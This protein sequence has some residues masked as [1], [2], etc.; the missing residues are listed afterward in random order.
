MSFDGT[1]RS[2]PMKG[3]LACLFAATLCL[4]CQAPPGAIDPFIGRQTVPPPG[5]GT[6]SAAPPTDGYYSPASKTSV[7][8]TSP[9]GTPYS[10]PGNSFGLSNNSTAARPKPGEA[11]ATISNG[12]TAPNVTPATRDATRPSSGGTPV[13]PAGPGESPPGSS[14]SRATSGA[15]FVNS[16]PPRGLP[17]Q[18]ASTRTA[19]GTGARQTAPAASIRDIKDLPDATPAT[20]TPPSRSSGG[21][22]PVGSATR[23]N[24]EEEVQETRE[25]PKS[26]SRTPRRETISPGKYEADRNYRW[27]KGKLEYSKLDERWKLRYI[28]IDG[29]TDEFG[30]SVVL[31][32]SRLMQEFKPGEYVT[33]YGTLG[34][35]DSRNGGFAPSYTVDRVVRQADE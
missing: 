19:S 1:E 23:A 32:G 24:Y 7:N 14:A 33:V 34:E 35:T 31:L 2:L 29:D 4:G 13:R 15:G 8:E 10:P 17:A 27:L 28:P 16:N 25:P 20:K 9:A 11:R 6:P 26:S 12:S 22:R 18:T 30:G 21:F 3:P 5:T